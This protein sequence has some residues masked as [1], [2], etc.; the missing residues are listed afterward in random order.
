MKR[1]PDVRRILFLKSLDDALEMR[2]RILIAFEA[3]E[4]EHDPA[5]RA[6][7]LTFVIVGGGPTGVELAGTMAEI[8]RKAMPRDFRAIDT[9]SRSDWGPAPILI[10]AR[11][12]PVTRRRSSCSGKSFSG[13]SVK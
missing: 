13:S 12:I 11:L 10:F 1:W 9:R 2:R 7:W 5:R 6:E 3:A 4:R 8:V